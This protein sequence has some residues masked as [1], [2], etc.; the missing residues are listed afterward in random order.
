M[1]FEATFESVVDPGVN[2]NATTGEEATS[3]LNVT[4]ANTPEPLYVDPK[5]GTW[6]KNILP[7]VAFTLL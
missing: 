3:P 4:V 6:E 7:E 5:D 1:P 2:S